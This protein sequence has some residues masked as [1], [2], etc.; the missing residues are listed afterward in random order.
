ME[1]LDEDVQYIF[2]SSV[3]AKTMSNSVNF[4]WSNHNTMDAKDTK[5]L[6]QA[7]FLQLNEEEKQKLYS[8]YEPDFLMFGYDASGYV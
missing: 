5:L 4:P 1:T 8:I 7:Y 2:E 3:N 6:T